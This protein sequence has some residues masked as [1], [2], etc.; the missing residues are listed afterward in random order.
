MLERVG[1]WEIVGE[2]DG[3]GDIV[4]GLFL[5]FLD[6]VALSVHCWLWLVVVVTAAAALRLW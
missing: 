6:F 5:D 1:A 3:M 2:D 4:F